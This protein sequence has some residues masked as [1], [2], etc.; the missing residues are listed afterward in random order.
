MR[1]ESLL[2]VPI[3]PVN[4]FRATSA[5]GEEISIRGLPYRVVGVAVAK[6]T[7]FGMPQDNYIHIPLKTYASNFGTLTGSRGLYFEG[8]SYSDQNF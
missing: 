4:C 6:G 7:L 1:R 8:T 2:S 5:V 3:L